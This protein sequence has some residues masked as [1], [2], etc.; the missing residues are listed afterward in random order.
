MYACI[1]NC[2]IFYSPL[3]Y[4]P[5]VNGSV[6]HSR[7]NSILSGAVDESSGQQDWP[8]TPSLFI[9]IVHNDFSLSGRINACCVFYLLYTK[10]ALPLVVYRKYH[11]I[12]LR[13]YNHSLSF[14][15]RL[16]SSV[17]NMCKSTI[18]QVSTHRR[19]R[20]PKSFLVDKASINY[21][22]HCDIRALEIQNK[23][24]RMNDP[25]AIGT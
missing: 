5:A 3:P 24:P 4:I 2:N 20:V 19:V 13:L 14:S 9:I 25:P 17:K 1:A 15:Y 10:S 6:S 7:S 23:P 12:Q 18:D 8:R 16:R 22:C 11:H 21:Y